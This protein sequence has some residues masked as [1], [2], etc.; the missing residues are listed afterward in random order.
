MEFVLDVCDRAALMRGGKI[1][2]S[3]NPMDIVEELTPHEKE[4]MLKDE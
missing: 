4:N 3:G 2:Q 1:L